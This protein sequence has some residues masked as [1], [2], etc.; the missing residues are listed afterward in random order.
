M[1]ELTLCLMLKP[2]YCWR[3]VHLQSAHRTVLLYQSG[4]FKA[5]AWVKSARGVFLCPTPCKSL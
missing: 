4:V 2:I 1:L 3:T 5:A